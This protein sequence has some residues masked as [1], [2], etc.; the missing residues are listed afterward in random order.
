MEVR[1]VHVLIQRPGFRPKEVIVVTTLV[2]PKLYTT[3][4]AQLYF[5][6][7]VFFGTDLLKKLRW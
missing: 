5:T 2:D 7:F 6:Q 1:E 4:L 3:K